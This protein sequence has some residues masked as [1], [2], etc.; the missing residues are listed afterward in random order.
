MNA[1][2][3]LPVAM[4]AS[5]NPGQSTLPFTQTVNQGNTI[6][7][8]SSSLNPSGYGQ[9]VTFTANP[10]KDG[11]QAYGFLTKLGYPDGHVFSMS[12]QDADPSLKKA[13]Q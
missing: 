6:T 7:Y 8:L 13:Q 2:G 3:K 9:E 4:A 11:S 10:A 12:A 5:H 1:R